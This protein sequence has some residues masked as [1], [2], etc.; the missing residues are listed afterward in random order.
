MIAGIALISCEK[1]TTETVT[2]DNVSANENGPQEQVSTKKPVIYHATWEEWGHESDD[3]EGW[4]LCN[5]TDCWFCDDGSLIDINHG[6]V[7]YD[8]ETGVGILVIELNPDIPEQY[9][10]IQGQ[11]TLWVDEDIVN[12]GSMLHAGEYAFDPSIGEYG[13]YSLNMTIEI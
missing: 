9:T 4:G 11:A 5:Y 10:A 1:E 8:D 2:P 7:T 13:G 12:E 3:C 6:Q